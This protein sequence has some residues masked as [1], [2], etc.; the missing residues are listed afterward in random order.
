MYLH[1]Y[2]KD[3]QQIAMLSIVPIRYKIGHCIITDKLNV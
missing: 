3:K 2:Y 1:E